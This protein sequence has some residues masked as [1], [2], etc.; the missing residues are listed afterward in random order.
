MTIRRFKLQYDIDKFR[1][2]IDALWPLENY[3]FHGEF[4]TPNGTYY[5]NV[6]EGEMPP[7]LRKAIE[8]SIGKA[9]KDFYFLWDWRCLTKVLLKHRDGWEDAKGNPD[10]ISEFDKHV[11]EEDAEVIGVPPLTVVVALENDFRIDIQ[12]AKTGEWESVT[13]GPGDI[14]FFNNAK[15]LHGGEVLNDP[16]NIPRRS[17]NCYVG[18]DQLANDPTFWDNPDYD[19]R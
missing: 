16:D 4:P 2:E 15:D 18:H 10:G 3:G 11:F 13:Y 8:D 6:R 17:L 9:I 5:Q 19:K 7:H 12:D 1:D 14:I